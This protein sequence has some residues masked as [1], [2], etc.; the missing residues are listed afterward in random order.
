MER[1]K[2]LYATSRYRMYFLGAI[3]VCLVL[4]FLSWYLVTNKNQDTADEPI[5]F[6]ET[7][8]RESQAIQTQT[9][10]YVDIKGA[11]KKPGIYEVK[12][13]MRVWDA[14]MLAGGMTE[15]ADTKQVNFAQRLVDQMVIIVPKIGEER[16][17]AEQQTKQS[18]SINQAAQ[19]EQV[20]INTA[21]ENELMTLTGIGQKKA[22]E[23]IR[24][25][26]EKGG[27]RSIEE[28]TEIA[29]IGRKTVEKLKEFICTE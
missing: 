23:I 25:R 26:E 11:V 27:F 7:S 19:S 15:E 2:T 17:Q 1:L 12:P 9:L 4:I 29:G 18:T 5:R 8:S 24:F 13:E 22:Q 10:V 20:N 28:L 14:L 16:F 3:I 6:S 21:S